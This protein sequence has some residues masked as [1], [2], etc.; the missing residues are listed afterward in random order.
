MTQSWLLSLLL[1]I[2]LLLLAATLMTEFKPFRVVFH[3]YDNRLRDRVLLAVVFGMLSILSTYLG[4][5]AYGAIINTRVISVTAAGLL[6]GFISGIGAGLIGGIHRYF[7]NPSSFSALGCCVG[8]ISFGVIGALGHKYCRHLTNNRMFL[9]LITI[10]GELC[11]VAWLFILARPISAVVTLESHILLPKILINSLGMVLFF[12]TFARFRQ[13]RL[14]ETTE[15]R[16]QALYIASC[17]LPYLRGGLRPGPDLQTMADTIRDNAAGYHVLLSDH[18][19]LLATSGCEIGDGALPDFMAASMA[20]K[21]VTVYRHPAKTRFLFA[22]S[23]NDTVAAPLKCGEKVIGCMALLLDQTELHLAKSDIR[24]TE[25]IAEYFSTILELNNL[26][27]EIALRRKAE[28]RAFQSQI[29]PHFFFNTLNTISALCRTDPDK[30][31]SLLL[32]LADYYRQTLSINEEFVTLAM[33][34]HN[35][36]DYLTIV[37]TR[38][39]NVIHFTSEVPEDTE[40][41]KLPPLII[42]PLVGNAVRHGGTSVDN[43]WVFLKI[44]RTGDRLSVSV[45]DKGHGFPQQVLDDLND[46]DNKRYSGLFN[47]SKRLVSIYGPGSRPQVKSSPE[48]STV[49][50]SIPV[51]PP[52]R[53]ER[54]EAL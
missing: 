51:V 11:Q 26:D 31:R 42:Q 38:F 39:V 6:G 18:E 22:L 20:E 36:D 5:D 3:P 34:L 37:N 40:T 7:Y 33:E 30:S 44:V 32:V 9:V 27:R 12:G 24:F 19:R 29:N 10:V 50:F 15:G 21:R 13:K 47:V 1:N 17:C 14:D 43:R 52:P 16:T 28:F 23:Q 25:T 46:P 35:L 49:S 53:P 4:V 8:T 2:S 48:G 41:C 45:S 54:S